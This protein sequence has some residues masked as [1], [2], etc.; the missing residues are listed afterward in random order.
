[1]FFVRLGPGLGVHNAQC[2]RACP[3]RQQAAGVRGRAE[4]YAA[5]VFVP[6]LHID[7]DFFC[8]LIFSAVQLRPY[9]CAVAAVVAREPAAAQRLIECK[10]Q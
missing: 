2:A 6:Y 1:M 7:G 9:D 3:D 10:L 5:F 8:I 4:V